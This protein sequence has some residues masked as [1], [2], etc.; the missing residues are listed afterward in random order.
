[1][2]DNIVYHYTSIDVLKCLFENYSLDNPYLTFWATNCAYMNDTK[3]IKEGIELLKQTLNKSLP[4][5]LKPKAQSILEFDTDLIYEYLLLGFT[6]GNS[7]VPYSISFSKNKDNLNMWRMYGDNGKGIAL[8]FY[9][10]KLRCQD[11]QLIDCV[12]N[13]DS[14]NDDLKKE[15]IEEYTHL[16]EVLGGGPEFLTQSTYEEMMTLC[17]VPKYV[18]K[19]KNKCYGYEHETRIIKNCNKPAF[20]VYRGVLIPYTPIMLPT[21]ALCKVVLGPD[22]DKRNKTSLQLFFL[23]KNLKNIYD[24]IIESEVPYRN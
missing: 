17:R 18:S 24:N 20:R 12:Y 21:D 7:E 19:V 2:E 6:L 8:G 22:C 16:Y 15:I 10:N 5:E 13:E 9:R 1:M 23:S 11:T 4:E 3:E 14:G